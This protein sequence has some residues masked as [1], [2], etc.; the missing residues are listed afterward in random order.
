MRAESYAR[1]AASIFAVIAVLQLARA[2]AGW[3]VTIGGTTIPVWPSWLAFVAAGG[4]AWLGF[5]APDNEEQIG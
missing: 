4:L 3:P 1:L 2:L 5:S